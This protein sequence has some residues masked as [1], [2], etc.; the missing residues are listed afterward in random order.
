MK[1]AFL[2]IAGGYC[3]IPRVE[4]Q[5]QTTPHAHNTGCFVYRELVHREVGL[6]LS[7]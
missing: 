2:Y 3:G 6:F 1:Q 5:K 4:W 7:S